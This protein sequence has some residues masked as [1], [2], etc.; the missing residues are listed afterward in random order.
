LRADTS[1]RLLIPEV[2]DR[3]RCSTERVLRLI[4]AGNLTAINTGTGKRRPR[5]VVDE[6]ALTEFERRRSN[7]VSAV[8]ST[9]QRGLRLPVPVL[10]A[11]RLPARIR[12]STRSVLQRSRSATSGISS[13]REVSARN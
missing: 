9:T 6:T 11:V 12:R 2:A 13:R 8:S 1:R 7:S 10:I 5:W 4:R 3:L